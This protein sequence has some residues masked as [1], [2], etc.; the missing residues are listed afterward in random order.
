MH[1][2]AGSRPEDPIR[3][4]PR[5]AALARRCPS[6]TR[7]SPPGPTACASDPVTLPGPQP[8]SSAIPPGGMSNH[9][10]GYCDAVNSLRPRPH[11]AP[12]PVLPRPLA[13]TRPRQIPTHRLP[14][15]RTRAHRTMP[16]RPPRDRATTAS[17]H[18]G[19]RN[20][21]GCPAR[22]GCVAESTGQ[23]SVAQVTC[24]PRTRRRPAA[25][26]SPIRP[27]TSRRPKSPTRRTPFKLRSAS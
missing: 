3:S 17:S 24:A 14:R 11:L 8:T 25:A 10:A 6:T 27:N 16:A 7:T 15:R 20:G 18:A 12:P 13:A 9:S 19:Q 5:V 22:R 4:G 1:P 23:L 26:R 2:R 21:I